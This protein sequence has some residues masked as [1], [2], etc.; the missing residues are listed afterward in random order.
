MPTIQ[1]DFQQL[2][3]T[4]RLYGDSQAAA[5]AWLHHIGQ[6]RCEFEG[7]LEAH[8]CVCVWFSVNGFRVMCIYIFIYLVIYLFIYLYIYLYIL[9]IY[10]FTWLF[11]CMYVSMDI[12]L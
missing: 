12:R 8:F 2:L 4:W 7:M 6:E 9:F 5:C 1:A 10:L 3:T 11:I